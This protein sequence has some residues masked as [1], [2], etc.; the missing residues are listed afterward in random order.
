VWL[1]HGEAGAA[2]ALRDA[3]HRAGV[4][5]EVPRPR[6]RLDLMGPVDGHA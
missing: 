3:F 6:L 4:R 2:A 1:V 5:A